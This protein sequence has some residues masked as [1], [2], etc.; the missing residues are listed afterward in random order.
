MGFYVDK[1]GRKRK[2]ERRAFLK[3]HPSLEKNMT[4]HAIVIAGL[5]TTGLGIGGY[6]GKSGINASKGMLLGFAI[7]FGLVYLHRQKLIKDDEKQS[8]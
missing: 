7:G 1:T 5:A 3:A 2:S 6:V 4:I 8:K